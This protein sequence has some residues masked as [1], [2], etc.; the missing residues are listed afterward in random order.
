MKTSITMRR[1]S[2]YVQMVLPARLIQYWRVPRNQCKSRWRAHQQPHTLTCRHHVTSW[3]RLLW[4]VSS[5]SQSLLCRWRYVSCQVREKAGRKVSD[6]PTGKSRLSSEKSWQRWAK[7]RWAQA[8]TAAPC[9]AS[10]S[11]DTPAAPPAQH[12]ETADWRA[13]VDVRAAPASLSTA[14]PAHQ[15]IPFFPGAQ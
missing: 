7:I 8:G 4:V 12:C 11:K 13:H 1:A 10:I 2:N 5:R 9:V 6:I 15:S 3:P 14:G